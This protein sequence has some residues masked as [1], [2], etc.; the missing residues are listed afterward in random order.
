MATFS[1][2]NVAINFHFKIRLYEINYTYFAFRR[3]Y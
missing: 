3:I 1:V 2:L